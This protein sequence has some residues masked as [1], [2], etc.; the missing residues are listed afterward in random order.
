[1]SDG[2]STNALR[3]T[4]CDTSETLAAASDLFNRY[5]HHYGES[6]DADEQT[7]GWLT[8]MVE[9]NMLIVY[10]ASMDSSEDASPMGIATAHVM[11]ASLVMG[12]FWQLRDL[13]VLPEARRQ[14]VAAALVST[15]RA[16]ALRAGARRLSLATEP[17]NRA[18]LDLYQRLGFR[19]VDGL[20]SLSVY[21]T[22]QQTGERAQTREG[23]GDSCAPPPRY[24][25]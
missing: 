11:P 22:P 10:A 17:D 1:M 19:P 6:S 9:T 15:V 16:A 21:L 14:G 20:V 4:T 2:F 12:Q 24:L 3:V 13:Y 5:R 18:A 8:D 7:L 23:R 25:T